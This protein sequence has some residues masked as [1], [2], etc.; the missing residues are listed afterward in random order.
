MR[1][2]DA[3]HG[4]GCEFGVRIGIRDLHEVLGIG[5][6]IGMRGIGNGIRVL[7]WDTRS[8]CRLGCG[9]GTRDRDAGSRCGTRDRDAGRGIGTRPH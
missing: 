3:G 4:S 6:E 8:A 2:R 1:N 7:N 9:I 5:I